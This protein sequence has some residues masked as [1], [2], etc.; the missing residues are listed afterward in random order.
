[1]LLNTQFD[2]CRGMFRSEEG[3]GL[4]HE[5]PK[6]SVMHFTCVSRCWGSQHK[7]S[8]IRNKNRRQMYSS[9]PMLTASS[10]FIASHFKKH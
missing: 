5:V 8:G 10:Y 6:L 3:P 9:E 7:I 2:I 1:M 4:I